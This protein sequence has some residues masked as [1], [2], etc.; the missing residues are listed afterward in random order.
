MTYQFGCKI[1]ARTVN[2]DIDVLE[3]KSGITLHFSATHIKTVVRLR[4]VHDLQ[5]I[6]LQDVVIAWKNGLHYSNIL[7]QFM[8]IPPHLAELYRYIDLHYRDQKQTWHSC[9]EMFQLIRYLPNLQKNIW[10]ERTYFTAEIWQPI[11]KLMVFW[12][13]I[14]NE[15]GQLWYFMLW[16]YG[17]FWLYVISASVNLLRHSYF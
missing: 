4:D 3:V 17:S 2:D 9:Y 7:C 13:M 5:S 8:G 14:L 6:L 16:V 10:S 11:W 1:C 12:V 15:T